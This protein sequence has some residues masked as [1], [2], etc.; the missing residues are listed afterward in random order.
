MTEAAAPSVEVELVAGSGIAPDNDTLVIDGTTGKQK[1]NRVPAN[2]LPADILGEG[3][4]LTPD[5]GFE[6]DVD[7]TPDGVAYAALETTPQG[8]KVKGDS[9]GAGRRYV[10]TDHTEVESPLPGDVYYEIGPEV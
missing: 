8:L 6:V 10:G 5:V 1:V 4:K 2:A 7:P 3:L 9:N